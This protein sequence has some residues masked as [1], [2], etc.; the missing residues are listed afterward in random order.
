MSPEAGLPRGGRRSPAKATPVARV[1]V[2]LATVTSPGVARA[3]NAALNR[4][5][6]EV[7]GAVDPAEDALRP[8][9]GLFAS[10]LL[11]AGLWVVILYLVW[12]IAH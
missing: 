10:A 2:E 8:A 7:P 9:R 1:R 6:A 3:A 11:G 12:L 4:R 5:R